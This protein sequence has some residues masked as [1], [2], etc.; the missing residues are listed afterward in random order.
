MRGTLVRL[1]HEYHDEDAVKV[2]STCV[3]ELVSDGGVNHNVAKAAWA[4]L[5]SAGYQFK[6]LCAHI[7]EHHVGVL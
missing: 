5:L 7:G 2:T 6:K 3:S 1:C 4:Q